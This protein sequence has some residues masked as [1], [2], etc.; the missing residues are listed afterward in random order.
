[1][2]LVFFVLLSACILFALIGCEMSKPYIMNTDR[3]DQKIEGNRGYL[4]GTPPPLKERGDLKRPYLTVDVEIPEVDEKQT[5]LVTTP[6]ET[7]LVHKN[8]EAV[9]PTSAAPAPAEQK[10]AVAKEEQIK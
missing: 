7:R 8:K 9:A 6:G 3:E 10:P 2:K 1:M 5:K 4:K